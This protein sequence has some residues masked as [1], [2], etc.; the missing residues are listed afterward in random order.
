MA[1]CLPP[2]GGSPSTSHPGAG[3]EK[4]VTWS[5]DANPGVA[6]PHPPCLLGA[7]TAPCSSAAIQPSTGA[8]D[9][10]NLTPGVAA[11][12]SARY[13]SAMTYDPLDGYTVLFGGANASGRTLRDTWAFKSGA[14]LSLTPS[15]LNVRDSPPPVAFASMAYDAVDH[16]VVLFGGVGPKGVN[17]QTWGFQAG[18]WNLVSTGGGSAPIA[19]VNASMTYDAS[20]GYLLLF[21]GYASGRPL[22]DTWSFSVGSWTSRTPSNL[23]LASSPTHRSGAAMS[24]DATDGATVLFG[25]STPAAAN[26][27]WEYSGGTWRNVT[28]GPAPSPR[29]ASSSAFDAAHGRLVLFGGIGSSARLLGE[30]WTFTLGNWTNQ[31]ASEVSAPTARAAPALA[32]VAGGTPSGQFVLLMGGG[33][34]GGAGAGDTWEFGVGALNVTAPDIE[35]AATDANHSVRLSA[36]AFGGS[37]TYTY[38]WQGL[39]PGC[40]SANQSVLTC[41][42]INSGPPSAIVVTAVDTQG[43]TASSAP[44]QLVVNPPP[45]IVGFTA[46]PYSAVVGVTNVTFLVTVSGGTGH[47]RF[48]FT[49]LPPGCGAP[50]STRF[51]CIP[52]AIGGYT[53]VATVVDNVNVT[54]QASLNLVVS[55]P[56]PS[57]FW[58]SVHVAEIAAGLAVVGVVIAVAWRHH[59]RVRGS[60]TAPKRSGLPE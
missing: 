13:G 9:W 21:G 38:V 47:L 49:G 37:G 20:D 31:T 35:P 34:S 32:T 41:Q 46:S 11:G 53:L 42:P 17:G 30:S 15:L 40:A 39:P 3:G 52:T 1:L 60:P 6:G 48:S 45:T 51:A 19:R 28:G 14:W 7:R 44:S 22:R 10:V 18:H 8:S 57:T 23:T 26:D 4:A 56:V 27:T 24:F 50:N 2:W 55:A 36:V 5:R 33:V 58:T 12:P 59:R 43:A 54:G 16:E 25:G 29:Y